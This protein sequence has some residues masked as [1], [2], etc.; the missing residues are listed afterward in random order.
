MER[1]NIWK[2]EHALTKH[3]LRLTNYLRVLEREVVEARD[4]L[5]YYIKKQLL[6]TELLIGVLK[7]IM[8]SKITMEAACANY[9]GISYCKF[10]DYLTNG[11]APGDSELREMAKF[12]NS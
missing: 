8:S 6:L 4:V 10:N 9:M 5:E 11:R 7:K 12:I 1:N 3:Y 2:T